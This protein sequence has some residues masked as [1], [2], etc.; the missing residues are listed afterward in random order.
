MWLC[1][2][3]IARANT[4]TAL[5]IVPTIAVAELPRSGSVL[6]RVN[7]SAV[8]ELPRWVAFSVA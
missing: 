1:P 6:G 3:K 2:S 5:A 7:A 4:R 8:V